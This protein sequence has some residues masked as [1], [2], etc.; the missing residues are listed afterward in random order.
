MGTMT[1]VVK[2]SREYSVELLLR[3]IDFGDAK[4]GDVVVQLLTMR[5]AD[6]GSA[7]SVLRASLVEDV[8]SEKCGWWDSRT[9]MAKSLG[10][11][12]WAALGVMESKVPV[13]N[14]SEV[15]QDSEYVTSWSVWLVESGW[16]E[17]LEL[18]DTVAQM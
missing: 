7:L 10:G 11:D 14:T 3:Q 17:L 5:A 16:E 2:V 8:D 18:N 1:A 15:W 6:D 4:A 12:K 13:L 9:R